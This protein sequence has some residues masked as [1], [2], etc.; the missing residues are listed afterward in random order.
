VSAEQ[1]PSLAAFLDAPAEQVA[2]VA[3]TTVIFAPGGTRRSAVLAGISPQSDEYA[4]WTRERMIKCSE[5][6]FTLGVRHL[7]MSVMRPPQ[8]A[9]VGRYRDRLLD[10]LDWGLSGPEALADYARRGWRVRLLGAEGLGQ[11]GT[12]AE[13]LRQTMPGTATPALW[14]YVVPE[15][16]SPWQWV[17]A[18]LTR[19][20]G[21]MTSDVIRALYGEDVPLATLYLAFGKPMFVPDLL[22][23]LLSGDIQCY[24]TQRPGYG[25]DERMLRQI[26]YDYAYLRPTW[27]RDKSARYADVEAHRSL[28]EQAPTLGL[29][30][31]VGA[32]WYPLSEQ[33]GLRRAEEV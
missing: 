1:L 10:W 28:W 16:E 33:E 14:Y 11:L 8:L 3:P 2:R 30:Q 24:W 22:P 29:G 20:Q 23:P 27:T 4:R 7:F 12:A 13:R 15:L 18:A 6:F 21:N 26:I 31:R 9:E 17:R 25:L 19:T 5:L 32:F